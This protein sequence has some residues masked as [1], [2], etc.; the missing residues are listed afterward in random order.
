MAFPLHLIDASDPEAT[1]LA[2]LQDDPV[3][4]G[5][6]VADGVSIDIDAISR[7]HGEFIPFKSYWL[8]RDASS[9]NGS[10]VNGVAVPS[11]QSVLV[12]PGDTVQLADV[13]LKLLS[14][15]GSVRDPNAAVVVLS[16]GRPSH[17][18][19]IVPGKVVMVGGARA[20]L[21]LGVDIEQQP[22]LIV[23]KR[24]DLLVAYAVA[25]AAELLCNG[26]PIENT[27]ILADRDRL[28]IGSYELL[29]SLPQIGSP[30][31]ASEAAVEESVSL[32]PPREERKTHLKIPFGA[33][34]AAA[35]GAT[36]DTT[37]RG[38]GPRRGVPLTSSGEVFEGI[39]R[40][41]VRVL[42]LALLL[43]VVLALVNWII[44]S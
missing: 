31:V 23:E 42:L 28:S 6:D 10:W 1:P 24:G 39:E 41:V 38:D 12:R 17:E 30:V 4:I 33:P 8:Y 19:P 11:G 29:I 26:A 21:K 35:Q 32:A 27:R 44:S 14:A 7:R 2:V 15:D 20:Q 5:R 22:S 40:L 37:E 9:T 34:V 13:P 36:S 43:G 25:Q 16:R 3:S 18:F